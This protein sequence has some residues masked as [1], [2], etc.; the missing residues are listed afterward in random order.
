MDL[1]KFRRRVFWL[2][3][4]AVVVLVGMIKQIALYLGVLR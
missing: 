2:G 3:L 4:L 1:S